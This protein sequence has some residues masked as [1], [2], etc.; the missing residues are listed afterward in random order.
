MDSKVVIATD[1]GGVVLGFNEK[2]GT[3]CIYD[4]FAGISGLPVEEVGRIIGF[5]IGPHGDFGKGL[6]NSQQFYRLL[7]DRLKI[8]IGWNEFRYAWGDIFFPNFPVIDLL[9]EAKKSGYKIGLI[10]NLDEL[11]W[12]WV[13]RYFATCLDFLDYTFLS[14]ELGCLKPSREYSKAVA[15]R[16]RGYPRK[17][18]IAIDDRDENVREFREFGFK[19]V[20][21]TGDNKKFAADLCA[22]GVEV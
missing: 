2:P 18:I 7:C 19:A 10:S 20:H 11:H 17:S 6:I 16:L 9:R 12:D 15:R 1:L 21:Y 8:F 5:N 22:L 3:N 14:F 13:Q 4:R